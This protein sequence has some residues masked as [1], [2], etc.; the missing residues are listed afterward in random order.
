MPCIYSCVGL[1]PD[2]SVSSVPQGPLRWSL[3]L[4]LALGLLAA[5]PAAS[6]GVIGPND[7]RL[8]T[9]ASA[10]DS[11]APVPAAPSKAALDSTKVPPSQVQGT[12]GQSDYDPVA[13]ADYSIGQLSQAAAAPFSCPALNSAVSAPG[14]PC[15]M[16]TNRA[17]PQG[18]SQQTQPSSLVSRPLLDQSSRSSSSTEL[19]VCPA[20]YRCSPSAAA[21]IMQAGWQPAA[22]LRNSGWRNA[23]SFGSSNSGLGLATA[24]TGI[25]VACQLGEYCPPGTQEET[26]LSLTGC[27]LDPI[28]SD[29]QG[30]SSSLT[31]RSGSGAGS[32]ASCKGFKACPAGSYCP[33]ASTATPCEPGRFC[34][35]ASITS[36]PCNISVSRSHKNRTVHA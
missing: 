27:E 18:Q 31:S 20:G 13:S 33:D 14:C 32:G 9:P 2:M 35:E 1:K 12:I 15:T 22:S 28:P 17:Q 16:H 30:G 23:S 6:G 36:Q 24:T 8:L 5:I 11:T 34:P 3:L 29:S 19:N 26:W 4:V 21:D 7:H 25:C 10:N